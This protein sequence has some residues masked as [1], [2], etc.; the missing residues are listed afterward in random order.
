MPR[1]LKYRIP[2]GLLMVVG[3]LLL[4]W[5]DNLIGRH[6]GVP[7]VVLLGLVLLLA[8]LASVELAALLR[9]KWGFCSTVSTWLSASLGCLMV[10]LLPAIPHPRTAVAFFGTAVAA[11]LF[12]SMFRHSFTRRQT[13]GAAAAGANAVFAMVYLGFLPGMYV[14]LRAGGKGVGYSAWVIAAVV[15]VVKACDV[16]AYTAGSLVGKRKLIP[17]LSPGKTWEGLAGGLA[18]SACCAVLFTLWGN[19]AAPP[20]AIAVWYAVP[21]GLLLGLVGQVGDLLASLL[22]RDA[23]VKD[24]AGTIPGFGGVMDVFDSLLLA[25]PVA[26]WLLVVAPP[27][28]G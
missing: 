19:A 15:L 9:A 20:R 28:G 27:A 4:V 5:A 16:G 18:F 7:G 2:S 22:K 1:M 11:V 14:L 3:L 21:A 10:Y 26:Y 8:A 13:E 24:W 17:W 23:G 6:G 12:G 25:G